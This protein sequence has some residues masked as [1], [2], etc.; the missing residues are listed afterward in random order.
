LRILNG[1][2]NVLD[3]VNSKHSL[4]I[5]TNKFASVVVY[6]TVRLRVSSHPMVLEEHANVGCRL[7]FDSHEFNNVRNGVYTSESIEFNI[8]TMD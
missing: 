8:F 5:S 6:A 3:A 4:K 1:R 7:I 2:G